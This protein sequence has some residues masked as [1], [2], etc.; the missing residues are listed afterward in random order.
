MKPF[1]YVNTWIFVGILFLLAFANAVAP[2][3]EEILK[4]ENRMATQ[5][6]ELT[7]EKLFDGSYFSTYDSYFA[8]HF[9]MRDHWLHVS[10]TA[11]AL[12][13][14]S[15]DSTPQVVT[16]EGANVAAKWTP[17]AEMTAAA[18]N[19]AASDGAETAA[20]RI[21]GDAQNYENW[22]KLLVYGDAVMEINVANPAANAHYAAAINAFGIH[23]RGTCNIFSMLIPTQI[24][25][26]KDE[27]Y[28]EMSDSQRETIDDMRSKL[29]DDIHFVDV[30]DRLE[31]HASEYIYFRTDHHWTQLGAKYAFESLA[32][33]VD[34][35]VPAELDNLVP[36]DAQ[37]YL[38]SLYTATG[39][40]KLT[41]HPDTVTY[42]DGLPENAMMD[43]AG[44]LLEDGNVYALKW[45]ETPQK[46]G[47]FLGGDRDYTQIITHAATGRRMLVL[48]DS[49]GNAMTPFL[50]L[51][52]DEIIVI[53]PRLYEGDIDQLVKTHQITDILFINYALVNRWDGYGGLYEGLLDGVT[54]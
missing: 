45:L 35:R 29:D 41:A 44:N 13:G 23:F 31:A 10:R 27:T 16:F 11:A 2:S 3:A 19:E 14:T 8:D 43:Q 24:E 54:P 20:E 30:Y 26:L 53:D 1:R 39:L 38:G 42:Y 48:K 5:K 50:T 9:V 51:I 17:E 25:F 12:S 34:G 37:G 4:T 32:E 6:P 52:A 33:A 18:D 22:G 7:M 49:Y 15:E 21:E 47:V 36:I 40:E 46:Y 28:R